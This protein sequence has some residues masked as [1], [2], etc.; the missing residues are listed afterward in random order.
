MGLSFLWL[1]SEGTGLCISKGLRPPKFYD[2]NEMGLTPHSLFFNLLIYSSFY[3]K[4]HN[5]MNC[6]VIVRLFKNKYTHTQLNNSTAQIPLGET[7]FFSDRNHELKLYGGKLIQ[8]A[9]HLNFLYN[10]E[11]P[12]GSIFFSHWIF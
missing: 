2:S 7:N 3:K 4:P 9:G 6:T 12:T 11:R 10:T 5:H 1:Y 8:E